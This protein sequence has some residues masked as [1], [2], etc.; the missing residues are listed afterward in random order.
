MI[1]VHRGAVLEGRV[2][3]EAGVPLRGAAVA[4][5]PWSGG[6]DDPGAEPLL[7]DAPASETDAAGRFRLSPAVAGPHL[8][9]ARA[10]GRLQARVSAHAGTAGIEVVLLRSLALSGRVE[11]ADGAAIVG[12]VVS[13]VDASGR[14]GSASTGPD[15][16]FR[17]DGLPPGACTVEAAVAGLPPAVAVIPAGTAAAV[18]RMPPA[19][20]AGGTLSGSLVLGTGAP[21]AFAAVRITGDGV[22]MEISADAAGEFEVRGLPPGEF[23]VRGVLATAGRVVTLWTGTLQVRMDGSR[24]VRL[25][26]APFG[27]G[28]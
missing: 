17:F 23:V 27:P 25:V 1:R 24:R 12:A 3:D 22:G 15:G 11:A 2:V 9:R 18:I 14:R 19:P 13:L 6:A 26:L 7:D 4:A 21:A 28:F 20:A 10:P 5:T 8:L 16:G